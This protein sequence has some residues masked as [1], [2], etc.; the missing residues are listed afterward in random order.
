M[1]TNEKIQKL[2]GARAAVYDSET[3]RFYCFTKVTTKRA[4]SMMRS[5]GYGITD[6]GEL[7]VLQ[8]GYRYIFADKSLAEIAND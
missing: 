8:G 6:S 3:E 4:S 1:T 5:A 7:W 2:T